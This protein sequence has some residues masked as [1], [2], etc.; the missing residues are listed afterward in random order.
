VYVRAPLILRARLFSKSE[1]SQRRVTSSRPVPALL[2]P[3]MTDRAPVD[4]IRLGRISQNLFTDY[5]PR[6]EQTMKHLILVIITGR[7]VGTV[8]FQEDRNLDALP[9]SAWA[10]PQINKTTRASERFPD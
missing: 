8:V 7:M 1:A 4:P 6:S 3:D 10:L 9:S 2:F 5:K